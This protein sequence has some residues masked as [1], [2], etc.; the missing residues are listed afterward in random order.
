[1]PEVA[2]ANEGSP[3]IHRELRTCLRNT[4]ALVERQSREQRDRFETC[5]IHAR[6]ASRHAVDRW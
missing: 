5:R 3:C 1:V 6:D 4:R 2:L